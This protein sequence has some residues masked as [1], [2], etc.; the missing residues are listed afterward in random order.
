LRGAFYFVPVYEQDIVVWQDQILE[1]VHRAKA[2]Q[3]LGIEPRY[4]RTKRYTDEARALALVVSQNLHRRHLDT[5]QRAMVAARIATMKHGGDRKSDQSANLR[6]EK[7]KAE[8]AEMLKVSPKSVEHGKAV[9][10]SGDADL[11]KQVETGKV[12]V[13]AAAKSVKEPKSPSKSEP[14]PQ[15][16]PEPKSESKKDHPVAAET[17]STITTNTLDGGVLPS[18]PK[19]RSTKPKPEQMKAEAE[20]AALHDFATFTIVNVDKGDLKLSGDPE[21]MRRW[22]DLKQRVQT[23]L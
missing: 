12:K 18:E 13:S 17:A 23:V 11:I 15:P 1:G 22:H 16:K 10:N 8:A 4:D 2:C 5:S 20:Y 7:S 3:K 21:P 14:K 6:L 19:P 9:I